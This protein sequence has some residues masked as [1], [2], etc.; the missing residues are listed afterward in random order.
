MGL[1]QAGVQVGRS[2]L[3]GGLCSGLRW[4]EPSSGESRKVEGKGGLRTREV[5]G[6]IR[7]GSGRGGASQHTAVTEDGRSLLEGKTS[8]PPDL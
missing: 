7:K 2:W 6:T 8:S 1:A 4:G 5:I 3:L